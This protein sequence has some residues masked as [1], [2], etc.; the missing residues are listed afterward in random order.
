MTTEGP[1]LI[2]AGMGVVAMVRVPRANMDMGSL[3]AR[4]RMDEDLDA[5]ELMEVENAIENIVHRVE[6]PHRASRNRSRTATRM[7]MA[8][9]APG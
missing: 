2:R 4:E 3:D 5:A 8:S 9:P 1:V 7:T 6:G